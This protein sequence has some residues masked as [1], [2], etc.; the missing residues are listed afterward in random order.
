MRRKFL[1][2]QSGVRILDGPEEQE[3]DSAV[4]K[5]WWDFQ[6]GQISSQTRIDQ[7]TALREKTFGVDDDRK[8]EI[9]VRNVSRYLPLSHEVALL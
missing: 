6:S 7:L 2:R 1:R 4:Q 5:I 8:K 3:F 9:L